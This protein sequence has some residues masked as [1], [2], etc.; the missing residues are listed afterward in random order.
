MS[1][2]AIDDQ[3]HV[4]A[5][6]LQEPL[7]SPVLYALRGGKRA[8]GLLLLAAG[9]YSETGLPRAAACVELLHA[10]TLVQDDIFDRSRMRRGAASVYCAF[11]QQLATLASDWMLAEAMRAAYR[12]GHGFGEALSMCAQR[13]MEAEALELAPPPTRTPDELRAHAQRVARGKTG[14]LFGLALSAAAVLSGDQRRAGELYEAG[15]GLGVAFQYL[16]DVIDLYG[17]PEI[18]G[19][20]LARDLESSLCTLPLLDAATKL[21][22]SMAAPLLSRPGD[23]PE[24]VLEALGSRGVRE[25]VMVCARGRWEEALG[26]VGRRF[27]AGSQVVA[28]LG[29]LATAVLPGFVVGEILTAA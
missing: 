7:R 14:E 2:Q 10:A 21:S 8:R 26:E 20:S 28:L 4:M 13:M 24:P 11:G 9:E 23:V 3:L 15:C 16:D 12:L 5:E 25:H 6:L 27:S 17:E 18:A 1:R 29:S 22:G 19:K